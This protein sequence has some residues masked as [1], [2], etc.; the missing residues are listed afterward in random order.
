MNEEFVKKFEEVEPS[1]ELFNFGHLSEI[2]R[3]SNKKFW[4]QFHR[5]RENVVRFARPVGNYDIELQGSA[6]LVQVAYPEIQRDRSLKIVESFYTASSQ[7][8]LVSHSG[9]FR[10][11]IIG[12]VTSAGFVLSVSDDARASALPFVAVQPIDT[13]PRW[14]RIFA[15]LIVITLG[16][17]AV[18][19]LLLLFGAFL[20]SV[21][22]GSKDVLLPI[23]I[24]PL[25]SVLLFFGL[26]GLRGEYV[27][28]RR[29]CSPVEAELAEATE[30]A[31]RVLETMRDG[32]R[33]EQL[34]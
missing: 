31:R 2:E 27:S 13:M 24:L 28:Y 22:M 11:P 30:A 16:L 5:Y 23:A 9:W 10:E 15:L 32:E 34:R 33:S 26:R 29:G 1:S 19:A 20:K 18:P 6:D 21:S 25:A 4:Y 7:H 17:S 14:V 8:C 12:R 3:Q